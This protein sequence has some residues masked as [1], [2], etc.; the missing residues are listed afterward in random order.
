[1]NLVSVCTKMLWFYVAIKW[2]ANKI[3]RINMNILPFNRSHDMYLNKWSDTKNKR[4]P[5]AFTIIQ[6]M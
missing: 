5:N 3:K 6:N 4:L 2:A 1:M